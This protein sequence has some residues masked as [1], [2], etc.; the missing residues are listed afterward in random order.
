MARHRRAWMRSLYGPQMRPLCG[1][2]S[3]RNGGGR[4]ALL[5]D[6]RRH[7]RWS[8]PVYRLQWWTHSGA[9]GVARLERVCGRATPD[10]PETRRRSKALHRILTIG[11]PAADQAGARPYQREHVYWQRLRIVSKTSLDASSSTGW[12]P[13]YSTLPALPARGLPRL[14]CCRSAD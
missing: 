6:P 12:K 10:A 5:L 8:C 14:R 11:R 1:T 3:R 7:V 4:D 13:M 2:R 9:S